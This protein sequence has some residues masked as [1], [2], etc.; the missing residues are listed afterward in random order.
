MTNATRTLLYIF[1]GLLV[2]TGLVK[3]LGG[4]TASEA[5]R[6]N[7]I[8]VDAERVSRVVI[9]APDGRS[10]E[11]RRETGNWQVSRGG[12]V[13]Y[14]ADSAA[15]AGAIR[16]LNSLDVV[17]VATRDTA[18]FTRYRV[19]ST[20]TRVDLYRD[21]DQ[22]TG[23]YVGSAGSAGAQS[24]SY[25]RVDGQD[26]VYAVEGLSESYSRPLEEWRDKTVWE[27]DRSRISRVD[28]IMPADSSYSIERAGAGDWVSGGDTLRSAP[29]STVISRLTT[30]RAGGFVD[31]LSPDD[32]GEERFAV[33]VRL[34]DGSQRT[35]RLRPPSEGAAEFHAVASDYPY[36]FT[37]NRDTFL[38][39][40]L[41]PRSALLR[42]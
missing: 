8:Q 14:E 2:L 21:R 3:W 18:K 32:F 36:L 26:A 12:E 11:L 29:V 37:L 6:R 41:R 27:V 35:L 13:S 1:V 34:E 42:Q 33:Q 24:N 19:D 39:E 4:Q 15:V 10:L 38:R 23:L 7:P 28:F 5:L 30:L 20:G 25:I 9:T 17:S 22:L 16:Q 40:V 31:T